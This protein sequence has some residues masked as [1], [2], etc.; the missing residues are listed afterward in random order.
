M[1]R[2]ITVAG[3]VFDDGANERVLP[4][5]ERHKAIH[6]KDSTWFRRKH[7]IRTRGF[8]TNTI[9][10]QSVGRLVDQ[11]KQALVDVVLSVLLS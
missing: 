9:D 10:N 6:K 8:K 5:K 7:F 11:A 2:F 4:L 1:C 3:V